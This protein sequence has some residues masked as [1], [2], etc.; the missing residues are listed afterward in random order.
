MNIYRRPFCYERVRFVIYLYA[1]VVK[2]ENV[3]RCVRKVIFGPYF[4]QQVKKNVPV[5]R[6]IL[7][8]LAKTD[9]LSGHILQF[10]FH[11]WNYLKF[12]ISLVSLYAVARTVR[13]Y[14]HNLLLRVCE[15]AQLFYGFVIFTNN[16]SV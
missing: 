4:L 2:D 7:S 11:H 6:F 13:L 15:G 1:T 5:F 12:P 10:Q 14:G 8:P 16:D 9:F 3:P